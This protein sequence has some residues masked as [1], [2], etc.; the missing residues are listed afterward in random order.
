MAY[1]DE[2]IDY[3][4]GLKELDFDEVREAIKKHLDYLP[5]N[6][7]AEDIKGDHEDAKVVF[8]LVIGQLKDYLS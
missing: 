3:L 2:I 4:D 7:I 8:E 6:E 5:F 1:R